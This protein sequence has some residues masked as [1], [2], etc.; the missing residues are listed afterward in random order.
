M[1]EKF[2]FRNKMIFSLFLIVLLNCCSF[3]HVFLN[4]NFRDEKNTVKF[5]KTNIRALKISERI[6]ISNNWSEAKSAGICTG[7]GTFSDPY[8]IEDLIIDGGGSGTGLLIASK[9]VYFRIENCTIFNCESGIRLVR[10]CNGTLLKNNCSY[11]DI[12]IYLDGWTD[13][14]TFTYE[15]YLTFYCMNNTLTNNTINNNEQYGVYMRHSDNNS[16]SWNNINQNEYG[17]FLENFSDNNTI[18]GNLLKKNENYGIFVYGPS[19]NNNFTGNFM[20]GCGFFDDSL[21]NLVDTSNL[22]NGKHLY[23]YMNETNLG[24]NDFID[25]GQIILLNCN[26]SSISNQDLSNGSISI[27]L[28]KCNN[29]EINQNNLSCNNLCG[30]QI[31]FCVNITITMNF[32]NRNF[33]GIQTTSFENSIISENEINFGQIGI[34]LTGHNNIIRRNDIKNNSYLGLEIGIFNEN[35]TILDNNIENSFQGML[36]KSV[37]YCNISENV[38]RGNTDFGIYLGGGSYNNTIFL[39]FFIDNGMHAINVLDQNW[40][41]SKIGNYWDDYNGTDADND[42][43]GDIPYNVSDSPLIQDF[44]PI[45]DNDAPEITILTPVNNSKFGNSAPSFV[46]RVKEKFI[47]EMWY[48][49]DNGIHNYTFRNNGTIDQTAWSVLLEGDVNL[50]FYTKDKVGNTA[51]KEITIYKR[52]SDQGPNLIIILSIIFGTISIIAVGVIILLWKKFR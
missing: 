21:G 50:V 45:V 17:I 42:G 19:I 18:I 41:N 8:V 7:F 48:T 46:V 25:A 27:Y 2:K 37:C 13:D 6:I 44:L 15:Q 10:S 34:S 51:F 22:V 28:W 36:L 43:I 29:I 14:P 9:I 31:R 12:G 35:I 16:L 33:N 26:D 5:K 23:L 38:I 47:D 40:N 49:L 11:N 20:K 30:L 39:N 3:N 32:I 52:I 1:R 24:P 4:L